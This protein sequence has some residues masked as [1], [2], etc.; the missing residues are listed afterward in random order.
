MTISPLDLQSIRK[1]KLELTQSQ[2]AQQL[3]FSTVTIGHWE[4]GKSLI[5]KSVELAIMWLM[6]ER[7]QGGGGIPSIEEL[8]K[9]IE[10]EA[11]AVQ[12]TSAKIEEVKQQVKFIYGGTFSVCF[13]QFYDFILENGNQREAKD[14]EIA[15]QLKVSVDTIR[16]WLGNEGTSPGNPGKLSEV[17]WRMIV[18]CERI[19]DR[20]MKVGEDSKRRLREAEE[21]LGILDGREDGKDGNG[22]GKGGR[23][24]IEMGNGNPIVDAIK[25]LLN[26]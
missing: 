14:T 3:G 18:M 2:L 20:A 17:L 7:M 19:R 25:E 24:E 5:P 4:N 26:G 22:G 16:R 11:A 8:E 15:L 21:N 23:D 12:G 9:D 6:K 1:H 13:R 10:R